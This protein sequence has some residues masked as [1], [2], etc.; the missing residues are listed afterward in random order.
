MGLNWLWSE[1]CGEAHFEQSIGEGKT[2]SYKTS[3][4][5]GNALLISIFEQD[6]TWTMHDFF[7]DKGHMNRFLGIDKDS[8]HDYNG[9]NVS[10][11]KLVR[12]ELDKSKAR[13]WKDIVASFSKAFPE[14]E[15]KLYSSS[16]KTEQKRKVRL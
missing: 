15:I 10:W 11:R 16:P 5:T 9:W 1:K 13:Y 4:Y 8:D 6:G 14:L 12:I 3:L 2:E 7:V